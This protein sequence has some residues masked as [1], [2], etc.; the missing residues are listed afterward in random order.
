M[1]ARSLFWLNYSFKMLKISEFSGNSS[2]L[3]FV[4]LFLAWNASS[5]KTCWA[6]Q[7]LPIG[8]DCSLKV[9][10]R[11]HVNWLAPR[12]QTRMPSPASGRLGRAVGEGRNAI[13]IDHTSVT[14]MQPHY[15]SI[16]SERGREWHWGKVSP[17]EPSAGSCIVLMDLR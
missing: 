3:V 9:C 16:I 4:W 12:P 14:Y 1:R 5:S 7:W 6:N 8:N 10:V 2:M 13:Y 17:D 15:G 11:A